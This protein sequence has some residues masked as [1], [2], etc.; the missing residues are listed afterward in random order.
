MRI[1]QKNPPGFPLREFHQNK[2]VKE[3]LNLIHKKLLVI[4]KLERNDFKNSIVIVL[5]CKKN[6]T[7]ERGSQSNHHH[8][9]T[10]CR[11]SLSIFRKIVA[12]VVLHRAAA[13]TLFR[14]TWFLAVVQFIDSFV[15]F[16]AP[17]CL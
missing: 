13:Q 5:R 6:L 3:F 2:F 15:F 4:V 11:M 16:A 12:V 1:F 14:N 7:R 8:N 10:V 9:A 17:P